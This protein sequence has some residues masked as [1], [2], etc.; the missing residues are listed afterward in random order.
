M[1]QEQKKGYNALGNITLCADYAV[2]SLN[3]KLYPIDII[4]SAAYILLDKAFILFDGDP[5]DKI[6]VEIRRK[7]PKQNVEELVIEFNEQLLNYGVYKIQTERNKNLR[8]MIMHKVMSTPTMPAKPLIIE[9]PRYS[10]AKQ[11]TED[12]E[13]IMIVRKTANNDTNPSPQ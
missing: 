11:H 9:D 7:S 13:G 4:Y 3:P 5:A 2:F 10:K 8:E 12:P 1:E 6:R